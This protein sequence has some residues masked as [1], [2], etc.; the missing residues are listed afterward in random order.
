MKQISLDRSKEDWVLRIE[1]MVW[2]G[3]YVNK[4]RR[5][6]AGGA[7]EISRVNFLLLILQYYT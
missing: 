5:G 6:G 3:V 4:G 7:R 1:K 2:V